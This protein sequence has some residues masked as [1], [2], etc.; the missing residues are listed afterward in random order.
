M[1]DDSKTKLLDTKVKLFDALVRLWAHADT[2]LWNRARMIVGIQAGI[3]AGSYAVKEKPIIAALIL[4]AG[5]VLCRALH[6]MVK[7]D[8]QTRDSYY[9]FI[10]PLAKEIFA[11]PM[12]P[13]ILDF[14]M[15]PEPDKKAPRRAGD[16]LDATFVS[17]VV[18]DFVLAGV[19][20]CVAYTSYF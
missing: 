19:F 5:A 8:E 10:D 14:R 6:L 4:I 18:I 7:R 3:L 15:I 20:L 17:L 12:Y 13:E 16:I 11:N 1:D 2:Y 9:R